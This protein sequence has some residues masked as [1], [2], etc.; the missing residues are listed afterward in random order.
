M[1]TLITT[2]CSYTQGG[3]PTWNFWLGEYYDNHI[4]LAEAGSGPKFS[5]VKIRDYFKYT[6][7]INPQDCHVIVQ[8]SSLLRNDIRFSKGDVNKFRCGG[9]V[10]NNPYLSDDYFQNHFNVIDSACDL[11]YYIESLISLSKELGFKLHMFYMFEPWV[12]KF[13]G[14]PTSLYK[15]SEFS[16]HQFKQFRISPYLKSLK[17]I[18][19]TSYFI[20]PS[21][22]IYISSFPKSKPIL[23]DYGDGIFYEDNHPSPIQHFEYFK[24]L[25]QK[26]K[27]Q[28]W[29]KEWEKI[30]L[31]LEEEVTT[32]Q[33]L[34]PWLERFW[35]FYYDHENYNVTNLKTFLQWKS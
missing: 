30:A 27:L 7:N 4:K 29:N 16:K 17:K 6:K 32:P 33:G 34:S 1:K 13:Y 20:Q 24:H 35:D 11:L 19:S 31:K 9:E 21:L 5:Y 25:S 12:N 2:G 8:W 15:N 23:V 14:E 3:Y 26:L 18:Y 28:T 10:G 22:E